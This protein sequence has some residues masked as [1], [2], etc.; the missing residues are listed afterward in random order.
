MSADGVDYAQAKAEWSAAGL[1]PLW[2]SAVSHKPNA[3]APR[4][5]AW[6]WSDLQPH[7]SR[8]VNLTSPQDVERR[9]LLFCDPELSAPGRAQT[10][11]MLN[12]GLQILM[13]GEAARAHRHTIDAIRLVLQGRGAITRVDG[14]DCAMEPGD[15]VLT[16]G[17]AWHEHAHRGT[18]PIVWLD[19]LNGPLHRFLGTALFEAGPGPNF[20]GAE[21]TVDGVDAAF[22]PDLVDADGGARLFRYPFARMRSALAAAAVSRSGFARVRYVAPE[23][24]ANAIALMDLSAIRIPRGAEAVMPRTNATV[25]NVVLEGGGV[26]RCGETEF[27]WERND[28]FITPAN[29]PVRHRAREAEAIVFQM[30]DREIFRRLGLL[31]EEGT[32]VMSAKL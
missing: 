8:A 30:S 29:A 4:L 22:R 27:A 23:S 1:A 17:G 19:G 7:I 18:E 9:V 3:T 15:L 21:Q 14:L 12:A 20:E 5:L 24:G 2:E 11:R 32:D 13:P 10:T 6:R 28:V 26:T 25:V 31:Q 16:P